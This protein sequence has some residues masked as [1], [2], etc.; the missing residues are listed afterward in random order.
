MSTNLWTVIEHVVPASHIR[1]FSR[2]VRDEQNNQLRLS[3]KQ[4]TPKANCGKITLV[5]AHGIGSAKEVYEPL[6]DELLNQALPIRS[7]WSIDAAHHG[8]SYLLNETTI[9]DEPHWLD[10][11]RDF[12]HVVTHFQSEM[13]PPIYGIGQSWG[14]VNILTMSSFHN[15]LFAGMIMMEPT[16]ETGY[17]HQITGKS[18]PTKDSETRTVLLAKRRDM[19]PSRADART[20]LLKNPYFAAYDSRVFERVIK[21]GLRD[22]PTTEHP[23]AV[24]LTTPKAQEVYTFGRPDPPFPGYEAAPGYQNRSLETRLITGFYRGEVT[25]IKRA[26]SDIYPP[27]LYLWGTE[28]DIGNSTYPQ[29][30]IDQTGTGDQGGGGTRT[31]QVQS[32]YVEGG[33]HLMPYK[34]PGKV[35]G[36]IA[37]WLR[38]EL[39]KWEEEATK[40]R[41]NQPPFDPGV[42]NPLWSERMSK[43]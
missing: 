8:Q 41:E 42:L 36:A 29:R 11:A 38:A 18:A 30:V 27:I 9:G 37:G 1:G 20:R 4:Y 16:F 26:L 31:G 15:R 21:Y 17:R 5:V 12:S 3:V 22:R 7:A 28:S 25:Q 32:K 10:P 19:W 39:S 2:G 14:C 40:R 33:D 23:H 6:L 24:T 13:S 34:L 43:L 35:A